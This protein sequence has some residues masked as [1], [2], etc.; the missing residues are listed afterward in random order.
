MGE[1]DKRILEIADQYR[2][3]QLQTDMDFMIISDLLD[4]VTSDSFDFGEEPAR[5]A[6]AIIQEYNSD[7]VVVISEK[8]GKKALISSVNDRA[9]IEDM[10]K[11]IFIFLHCSFEHMKEGNELEDIAVKLEECARR[12][13]E[14]LMSS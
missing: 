12:L 10:L 3:R 7:K 9:A 14:Y 13:K 2:L 5:M 4:G 11:R 8:N 6:E 1:F